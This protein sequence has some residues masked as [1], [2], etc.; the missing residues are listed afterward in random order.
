MN[1]CLEPK[2]R[3]AK[4]WLGNLACLALC[5]LGST[6]IASILSYKRCLWLDELYMLTTVKRPFMD[7]LLQVEDFSA[8]IYQAL[9][10]LI[11]GPDSYPPEWL[12]RFPALLCG[13]AGL[14]ATW[15]LGRMLFNGKVG[16]ISAF[17][18]GLNPVFL[19]YAAEGRPY[20][21]FLLF[22]TCSVGTFYRF[23]GE[24]SGKNLLL[25]L[26]SSTLLVYSHYY[27]LFL[28]AGE[29][30]FALVCL[31]SVQSKCKPKQAVYAFALLALAAAPA[32][33]LISRYMQ[34]GLSGINGWILRPTLR[35]FVFVGPATDLFHEKAVGILCVWAIAVAGW[36][37]LKVFLGTRLRES[38][39]GT[40]ET[41]IEKTGALPY[42]LC[43][44]W[45]AASA[46][47]LL[48]ISYFI[49]PIYL[50]RYT[51]PVMVPC[52]IILVSVFCKMTRSVQ[53]L[54]VAVIVASFLPEIGK[55]LQASRND[56]PAAIARIQHAGRSNDKI[57][58]VAHNYCRDFVNPVEMGLKY[59]GC[60]DSNVCSLELSRVGDAYRLAIQNQ[61]ILKSQNRFFL[62]AGVKESADAVRESLTRS[63]RLYTEL[64]CG[65][66]TLFEVTK[67]E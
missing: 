25:Y 49:K 45:I 28:F 56:Y 11:I 47:A 65:E 24:S 14:I 33:W 30:L 3:P 41:A 17:I 23:M 26:A 64:G 35:S 48:V 54:G 2:V 66:V 22:S 18:V 39:P 32:L 44:C 50:L 9:L 37:S 53:G 10:R 27:G 40:Q 34:S 58:A 20:T 51:F 52:A 5:C 31:L 8:P 55:Q 1:I 46:Y 7:A 61:Q 29:G 43:I 19:E 15:W 62:V 21:M 57:Y 67:S 36:A 38:S 59:Y 63:A 16:I 13:M 12:I 6:F 60:K 4:T 42:L